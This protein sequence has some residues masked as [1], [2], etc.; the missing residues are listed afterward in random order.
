MLEKLILHNFIV[1]RK[2]TGKDMEREN[3]VVNLTVIN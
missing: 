2:L 3:K 1:V